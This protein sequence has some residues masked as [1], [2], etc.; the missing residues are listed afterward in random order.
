MTRTRNWLRRPP[1][2]GYR[3]NGQTVHYPA[4][5]L[6]DPAGKEVFRYVGKSNADRFSYD[7]FAAKLTE[8]KD[9]P[10]AVQH[11]NLGPDKVALKGYD[12]Y[13]CLRKLD[14]F[15]LE[16]LL[17]VAPLQPSEELAETVASYRSLAGDPYD[18]YLADRS[19]PSLASLTPLWH[20]QPVRALDGGEVWKNIVTG[21]GPRT[22]LPGIVVSSF[23]RGKIVYCASALESLYVQQNNSAVGEAIRGLVSK[24][25]AV[26]PPYEVEVPSALIVNL[27]SKEDT[28][29]LH[30]TNWTGNKLQ[31]PGANEYYLA[32]V[33]NV[34]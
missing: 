8:L 17:R 7:Q 32:S 6:L 33:E 23:G 14:R 24:V 2:G 29:V 30:L 1:P 22:I 34:C 21:D 9:K 18:L 12:H 31:R 13:P 26:P 16:D 3:F 15:A 28:L 25:A 19:N 11:Y 20:Y 10:A 4:L 27:T 5:V